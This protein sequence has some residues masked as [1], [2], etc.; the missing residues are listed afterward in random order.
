MVYQKRNQR[1]EA[2][3]FITKTPGQKFATHF[4][5]HD[6]IVIQIK[7]RKKW[8]LYPPNKPHPLGGNS[9]GNRV[10]PVSD[11][12]LIEKELTRGDILVLPRGTIH[13]VISTGPSVHISLGFKPKTELDLLMRKLSE[14]PALR[15]NLGIHKP[16]NNASEIARIL[17]DPENDRIRMNTENVAFQR[18]LEAGFTSWFHLD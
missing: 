16:I 10:D 17:S 14:I 3:M 4:D 18:S 11:Q 13:Q 7:G 2:N 15:K 5:D 9:N 12:V 1:I 8:C 6:I